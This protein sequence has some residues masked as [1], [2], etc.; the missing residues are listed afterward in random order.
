METEPPL[1]V[2][3]RQATEADSRFANLISAELES[4]ALAR[5]TGISKRSPDS[6][7]RKM[8]EGKAVIAIAPDGNWAGF[9]YIEVWSNGE[10]V[11][12]SGLIVS[13]PYR[14]LGV[15]TAIKQEIFR[16]SGALYP[17]AKIFSI[18]TGLAIMR[19]NM[20]LGFE[21]VTFKEITHDETFW[22]GCAS[23]VNYNILRSKHCT[24]CL[25]TAMLF[26][27][28]NTAL[29]A[30]EKAYFYTPVQQLP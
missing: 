8:E 14:K 21:P 29:L 23:C 10:F 7:V 18:T 2:L 25:C 17:T 30:T 13:P 27:P 15:A 11:S 1:P 24:N 5:G 19:M 6:I 28:A 16:L 22:A 4:S 9:S 3:V 26:D 20:A 12:N